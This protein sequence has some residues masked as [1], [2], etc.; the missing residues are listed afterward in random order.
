[1][2]IKCCGKYV[3]PFFVLV[4]SKFIIISE[5][6]R[7]DYTGKGGLGLNGEDSMSAEG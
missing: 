7:G 1:M 5:N 2:E 3:F 6:G 4:K